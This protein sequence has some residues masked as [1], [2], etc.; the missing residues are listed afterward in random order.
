MDS[1]NC[2]I[3]H[4]QMID[5]VMCEDG[6]TYERE[7]I[8]RWIDE[9]MI[10]NIVRSPLTGANMGCA[11]ITNRALRDAIQEYRLHGEE[12]ERQDEEID[13]IDEQTDEQSDEQSD[14]QT[15]P[16]DEI[17]DEQTI[18]TYNNCI[19]I[20]NRININYLSNNDNNLLVYVRSN[21]YNNSNNSNNNIINEYIQI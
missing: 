13:Q 7:A 18:D 11:I 12:V 19:N 15:E 10:N 3:T 1:F 17:E 2:P 14:E 9:N 6:N 8:V 16:T 4:V 21:N 20:L 5:P